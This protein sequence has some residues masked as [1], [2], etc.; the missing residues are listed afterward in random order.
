MSTTGEIR[1][2][3][4]WLDDREQRAWR[5]LV[6]LIR[7]L[8]AGMEADLVTQGVS[9]A[10]FQLLVPLSEG[11]PT[12]L[13]ARDLGRA[14]GWDRSRLSHQL[15]RMEER[16]L[17]TRGACGDDARG[18][19][20]QITDQGLDT[21]RRVAPGHVEWVR[22]HVFDVLSDDDVKALTSLAERLTASVS[23]SPDDACRQP[24]G[25]ET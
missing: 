3:P 1:M 7:G 10:D 25:V 2:E 6:G 21:V 15:R 8:G 11:P 14:V 23:P 12:G 17:V 16:G 19:V 5:A 20:I 22:S 24:Q 4:R 9:G 18:I 13:R